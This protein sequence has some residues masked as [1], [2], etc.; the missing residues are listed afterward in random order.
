M[1]LATAE[2][3]IAGRDSS[4]PVAVVAHAGKTLGGGLPELRKAL[5]AEGCQ[6]PI[7]YEVPK[8]RKAPK[9]VRHA[10]S[11]GAD[12]IFVWGGDG[13]VQRC[14]DAAAGSN[15]AL[16][17]IP[18]GTANLLATGLGIPA[19]IA[20]AVRIGLHGRRRPMDT[21][22][23]NGEHFA[24]MAGAGFDAEMME[25]AD[26]GLK[27]KLGPAAYLYTGAR[28][29][30]ASRVKAKIKVDGEP[31]HSGKVSC[32]L[33]GNVGRVLGGI[34]VFPGARSDDGQLE[35]GVV[36]ASSAVQWARVF[37]RI[38]AGS[39]ARSPFVRLTCG[40]KF[41]LKFDRPLRYE[42][43]GGARSAVKKLKIRVHPSSVTIC[44]P[45]GS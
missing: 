19:D 9:R 6:E 38:A 42:L 33:A 18:A 37:G 14:I 17:I 44:V 24:V 5:A 39:A 35:L 25:Q 11:R 10:I 7:W 31:F 8:S 36:T 40:K 16:A 29:I 41:N 1:A 28:S 21:G 26:G 32:V 2:K 12:L 22:T 13:S 20:E 27:D 4:V 45:S 34:E 23:V 30:A 15:V 3:T 43:D